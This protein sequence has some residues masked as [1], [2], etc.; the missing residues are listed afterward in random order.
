MNPLE[1]QIGAI[2][3]L[4][5][6]VSTISQVYEDPDGDLHDLPEGYCLVTLFISH[7]PSRE[8]V[9]V[10]ATCGAEEGYPTAIHMLDCPVPEDHQ[11]SELES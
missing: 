1:L 2:E 11:P 9:A 10:C 8:Q 4:T 3:T 7:K 6:R 5:G